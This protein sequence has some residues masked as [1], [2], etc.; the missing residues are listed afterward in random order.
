MRLFIFNILILGWSSSAFA[1]PV[2]FSANGKTLAA[3]GWV[4]AFLTFLPVV[5]MT[6]L[7]L[8]W[9][10]QERSLTATR[11]SLQLVMQGRAHSRSWCSRLHSY[12]V[13]SR[14]SGCIQSIH[15]QKI[16]KVAKL[17]GAPSDPRAGVLLHAKVGTPIKKGE[18]LFRIF[19][20]NEEELQFAT[21]YV[22]KNRDI[23]TLG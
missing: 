17:A 14:A 7:C 9:R 20:E 22:E 16:A 6:F 21:D 19:A 11:R 8:W 1:C 3:Y 23:I 4:T 13:K 12:D 18:A 10:G 15:N 5:L 2:C